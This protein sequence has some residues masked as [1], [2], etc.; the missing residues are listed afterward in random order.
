MKQQLAFSSYDKQLKWICSFFSHNIGVCVYEYVTYRYM[1]YI[2]NILT[3]YINTPMCAVTESECSDWSVSVTD[4]NSLLL[5]QPCPH[6]THCIQSGSLNPFS[7]IPCSPPSHTHI[8][9]LY[10]N[11][12]I[13]ARV[14][15]H[16]LHLEM[17][18]ALKWVNMTD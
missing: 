13:Y 10:R 6:H 3:L 7:R 15:P 18:E 4:G 9:S 5:I 12:K 11:A 2:Y 1:G 8:F 17:P 16:R 14:R